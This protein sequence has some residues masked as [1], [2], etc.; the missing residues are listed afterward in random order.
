MKTILLILCLVLS[1]QLIKAEEKSSAAYQEHAD[2]KMGLEQATHEHDARTEEGHA[3]GDDHGKEGQNEEEETSSSVGPGNAVTAADPQ[4]GLQLSPE[5][6][7]T[8][9]IESVPLPANGVLPKSAIVTFKDEVGVYRLRNGWFKLVE[10]AT[11]N[12]NN[13][14]LFIPHRPGDL[15]PGDSVVINGA[16]L[17]RVAELDAFSTG[18]AGHGH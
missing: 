5:A 15:R 1:L 13:N 4:K 8:L 2:E 18:N 14:A 3:D 12:R 17:L 16:P 7:G 9:A 6:M 10:G 11:K